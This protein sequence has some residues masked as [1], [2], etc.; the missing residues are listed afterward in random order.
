MNPIV[1]A[2]IHDT[3]ELLLK[4][5]C[6]SDQSKVIAQLQRSFGSNDRLHLT[7]GQKALEFHIHRRDVIVRAEE[8]TVEVR[9]RRLVENFLPD[10]AVS[11]LCGL[12]IIQIRTHEGV[13]DVFGTGGERFHLRASFLIDGLHQQNRFQDARLIADQIAGTAKTVQ[14]LADIPVQK[15]LALFI[16]EVPQQ[17]YRQ[18]RIVVRWAKCIDK[19]L[20]P[21][22]LVTGV[23]LQKIEHAPYITGIIAGHVFEQQC[24]IWMQRQNISQ[25]RVLNL[26][27]LLHQGAGVPGTLIEF[28]GGF[29]PFVHQ[30]GVLALLQGFSHQAEGH[31]VRQ[32]N[33][34]ER[35]HK[36]V[37]D[38]IPI[39]V[40]GREQVGHVVGNGDQIEEVAFG[41]FHQ[42]L[43]A[44]QAGAVV[45]E[46]IRKL[47]PDEDET[48]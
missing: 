17:V 41:H 37:T 43:Q 14:H 39:L 7:F 20:K 35:L 25:L 40:L 42:R 29:R 27:L 33:I 11:D 5:A 31:V 47:I 38:D 15:F 1:R 12:P 9:T 19:P 46:E 24:G 44:G 10:E 8:R 22:N 13:F 3:L 23:V 21:T 28:L 16:E 48:I 4:A 34:A 30:V 45:L 32:L 2:L 18:Q 36:A 26:C 6:V